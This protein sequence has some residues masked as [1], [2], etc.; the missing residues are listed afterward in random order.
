LN[1]HHTS[2]ENN[3]KAVQHQ[4][5]FFIAINAANWPS[6]DSSTKSSLSS[7]LSFRVPSAEVSSAGPLAFSFGAVREVDM[8]NE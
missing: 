2:F 7:S 1:K 4:H 5:H 6:F 3:V 8:N